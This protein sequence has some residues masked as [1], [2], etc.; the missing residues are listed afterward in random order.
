MTLELNKLTH[1]LNR[2]GAALAERQESRQDIMAQLFQLLADIPGTPLPSD[3]MM[4]KL[5]LPV[6]VESDWGNAWPA[7][8]APA[9][10]TVIGGDGSTIPPDRHA[11]ALYYI[12][13][14][15]AI[16]Y[17]HGSQQAPETFCE[18]FLAY[19]EADLYENKRL[20]TSNTVDLRRDIAEI[21]ILAQLMSRE[22]EM[23]QAELN[24]GKLPNGA[25]GAPACVTLA[26]GTLL[27]W[28]LEEEPGNSERRE[29]F[30]NQYVAALEQMRQA[31]GLVAALTSRPRHGEIV[32]LLR[33]C[34]L[35]QQSNLT[36][37]NLDGRNPF[38]FIADA[39]LFEDL[40]PGWRSACFRSTSKINDLYGPHRIHFFYLNVSRDEVPEIVR[41]EVPAWIVADSEKI[42]LIQGAI[43][44]QAD[45]LNGFPYVL[46]RAHE[47][48][49]ITT[50]ER[51]RFS[52]MVSGELLLNGMNAEPSKKG[53]MKALTGGSKRS[54][55]L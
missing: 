19:E 1:Q 50:E 24:A 9:H 53:Q 10:L 38:D 40:P 49:V 18:P 13:N 29:R 5:H 36:Q 46:A 42:E 2:M 33:A 31:G 23:T 34:Q 48:A 54:H 43:L 11:E 55:R 17:R 52:E 44:T 26:D 16:I 7:P 6:P 45:I 39:R 4:K 47:L 28:V 8:V 3:F 22:V 30:V 37:E 21:Q 41:V 25:M 12:V 14:T 51:R 27:L 20:I 35:H 32:R 15:G